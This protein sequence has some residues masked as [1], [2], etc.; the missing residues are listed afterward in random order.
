MDI[1]LPQIIFQ[2]INFGVV[3][4]ALTYLLYKPIQKLMDERASRIVEGQS[5]AEAALAQK[6]NLDESKRKIEREAEKKAAILIEEA[7]KK[8]TEI[9]RE[10]VEKARVESQAETSKLKDQWQIEKHQLTQD[11]RQEMIRAVMTV[12]QKV[13][14]VKLDEKTDAKLIGDELSKLMK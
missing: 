10:A 14:G 12:T 5:A 11:M 8:A 1:Q 4:G 9:K 7:A 6:A 3:M 2:V 13:I